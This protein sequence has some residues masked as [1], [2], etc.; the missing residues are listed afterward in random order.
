MSSKKLDPIRWGWAFGRKVGRVVPYLTVC[1]VLLT[2]I[3]QISAL[4]A[5]FLPLKVV[6]LLGSEGMPGYLPSEIRAYGKDVLVGMFSLV[7]VAFYLVHLLS[8]RMVNIATDNASSKLLARSH[9]LVLFE[10][11]DEIAAG[12]YSRYSRALASIIFA[13]LAQLC[14]LLLYPDMAVAI[15]SYIVV[16]FGIS[17]LATMLSRSFHQRA[18]AQ[19]TSSVKVAAGVGFF[20]SFGYLV[21][22]FVFLEPP[23][24]IPAIVA[25]LLSRMMLLKLGTAVVDISVLFKQKP[26]MEALF[27][28]GKVFTPSANEMDSG[29][30][31]L[32][33][34]KYREQ[35]LQALLAEY[36]EDWPGIDSVDFLQSGI[37]NVVVLRVVAV[38][39]SAYLVKLFDRSKTALAL[40]EATLLA[41]GLD[42]LP[43]LQLIANTK[44]QG[45]HCL[46]YKLPHGRY[47]DRDKFQGRVEPTRAR[48]LEVEIPGPLAQRYSRSKPML[49]QRFDADKIERLSLFASSAA[50]RELVAQLES[51]AEKL[52]DCLQRLPL[53]LINAEIQPSN[54]YVKGEEREGILLNWG[55]WSL[56]PV[57]AGW[58]TGSVQLSQLKE[59]LVE[60]ANFRPE[61]NNVTVTQAELAALT[62]AVDGMCTRQQYNEAYP[63]LPPLLARL[64]QQDAKSLST[65][66]LVE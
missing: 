23:G 25:L 30:W 32:I 61:L 13:L 64:D 37:R 54:L 20:A 28:H 33:S 42:R 57:G 5:S 21:L 7:T 3:S 43:G 47:V 26:R 46:V 24:V 29:I 52:Q 55:Q 11:Q 50:H 39:K 19:L 44:V 15:L 60:A 65:E 10:N 22:D 8:E 51:N 18:A 1:I 12:A 53:T 36:L 9:K 31:S 56:D 49:W 38:D 34:R 35:W 17:Y 41:E 62:Y 48:L 4:V 66:A 40:H 14:L 2:L 6:I 16:I 45:F 59:A 63:L 58:R 27:F